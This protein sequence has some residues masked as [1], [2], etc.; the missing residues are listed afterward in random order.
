MVI[1]S[2]SCCQNSG[3]LAAILCDNQHSSIAESD[4]TDFESFAYRM[5]SNAYD[6]DLLLCLGF[7]SDKAALVA[8]QLLTSSLTL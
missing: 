4:N 3:S 6:V 8:G 5:I 1:W 2:V 7:N